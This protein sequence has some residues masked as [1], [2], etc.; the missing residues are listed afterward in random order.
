MRS[1]KRSQ[2]RQEA[3]PA[4]VDR[5]IANGRDHE[6]LG[7]SGKGVGAGSGN[8]P[9]RG[10]LPLPQRDPSYD[11]LQSDRGADRSGR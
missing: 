2:Y 5:A 1:R 11:R 6:Q 9:Y 10:V 8:R 4:G 3:G 7:I